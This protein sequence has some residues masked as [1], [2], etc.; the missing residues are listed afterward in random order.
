MVSEICAKNS[1]S[2]FNCHLKVYTT[3]SHL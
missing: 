2:Y 1:S 3:L